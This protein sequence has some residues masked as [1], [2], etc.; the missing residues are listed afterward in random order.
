MA[1]PGFDDILRAAQ[2]SALHLETRDTYADTDPDFAAWQA[3]KPYDR[4]DSDAEWRALIRPLVSRGVDV[5]RLR[6][7]SEPVSD[8][9]RWE[10]MITDATSITAGE[11][12][13]WLPRQRVGN[14]AVP[15]NDFWLFDD[16]LLFNY[17]SGHGGWV[18][19]EGIKDRTTVAFCVSA[20]ETLWQRGTDHLKYTP[21]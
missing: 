12:V 9:I 11:S 18:G 4:S 6:I 15:G 19:G 2:R 20:F 5:R 16:L 1:I 10:Y 14:L 17:F 8:Y 3:G 21:T 13:R 7:V